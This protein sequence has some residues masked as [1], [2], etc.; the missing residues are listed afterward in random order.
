L[1]VD[2]ATNSERTSL[3]PFSPSRETVLTS[4]SPAGEGAQGG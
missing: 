4:F 1:L 2:K 3:A